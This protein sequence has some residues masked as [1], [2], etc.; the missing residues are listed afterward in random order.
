MNAFIQRR[1]FYS[2]L[3]IL[4]II[5]TFLVSDTSGIYI[6]IFILCGPSVMH[7]HPWRPPTSPSLKS[8]LYACLE[9]VFFTNIGQLGIMAVIG[10]GLFELK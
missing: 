7:A 4:G 5:W 8:R 9:V 10:V 6:L 1:L 2:L 3:S